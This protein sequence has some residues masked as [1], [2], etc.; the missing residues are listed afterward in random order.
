MIN[1]TLEELS[2]SICLDEFIEKDGRAKLSCGF[3]NNIIHFKCY[4]NYKIKCKT[5]K[6]PICREIFDIDESNNENQYK[7]KILNGP[8]INQYIEINTVND[9]NISKLAEQVAKILGENESDVNSIYYKL[10]LDL[11]QSS[12]TFYKNGVKLNMNSI[13][14]RNDYDVFTVHIEKEGW[15][16]NIEKLENN[17][18]KKLVNFFQS[19]ITSYSFYEIGITLRQCVLLVQPVLTRGNNFIVDNDIEDEILEILE[20]AL[21][22]NRSIYDTLRYEFF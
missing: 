5:I 15:Q 3:C 14:T 10:K 4:I 16:S 11:E 9:Y 22:N 17:N 18:H 20:D 19:N 12:L 2:C 1:Q 13:V 6:C 7:I 21:E 8:K